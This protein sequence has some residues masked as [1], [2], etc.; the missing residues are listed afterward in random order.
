[1]PPA[2]DLDAQ[3]DP[4]FGRCG[5]FIVVETD[6]MAFTAFDNK[7][8]ALSGSAGI[9]SASFVAN[10]GVDCVLTGNCGPKAAAVF[11]S[12]GIDVYTGQ[13]GTVRE[14]IDR[15]KNGQIDSAPGTN[16]PEK[17]GAVGTPAISTGGS[18][19]LGRGM[20]GG[21]RC[22]GR[23]MGGGRRCAGGGRGMGKRG[24]R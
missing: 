11:S 5:T 10:Q 7:N 15:F 6:D 17:Y 16:V 21:N 13:Y 1:V 9:Q 2:T 14:V 12:A 24:D 20:G 22:G 8:A 3:V 23:G 4:R 18:V 19:S